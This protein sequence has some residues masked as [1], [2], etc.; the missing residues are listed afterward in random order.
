MFLFWDGKGQDFSRTTSTSVILKCKQNSRPRQAW[1]DFSQRGSNYS[2][3]DLFIWFFWTDIIR[4]T[5]GGKKQDKKKL[6]K[7]KKTEF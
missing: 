4:K 3:K 1:A 7:K 5:Y 2:I 6:Q